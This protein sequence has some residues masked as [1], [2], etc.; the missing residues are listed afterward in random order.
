VIK[1]PG[2]PRRH[3]PSKD[4]A[5]F[6]PVAP[7]DWVVRPS[8]SGSSA[9]F[10]ATLDELKG[11]LRRPGKRPQTIISSQRIARMNPTPKAFVGFIGCDVGES[12]VIVFDSRAHDRGDL[13]RFD[14]RTRT[15]Q[16]APGR[17]SRRARTAS[18]AK[19]NA[20]RISPDSRRSTSGQT[21]HVQGRPL[22]N[23]IQQTLGPLLPTPHRQRK[24][25]ARRHHRRHAKTHRHLQRKNPP[26]PTRNLS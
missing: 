9:R 4:G 15:P 26:N 2:S 8:S 22:R 13:A 21:R 25:Q 18:R 24:K 3:S 5:S 12:H 23:P 1:A 11:P 6:D 14:A 7:C 20:G 10:L 19:R 17:S 16:P